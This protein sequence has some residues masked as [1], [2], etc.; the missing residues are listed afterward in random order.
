[1]STEVVIHTLPLLCS[2]FAR[3]S[4]QTIRTGRNASPLPVPFDISIIFSRFCSY[5]VAS[6]D[7]IIVY[8]LYMFSFLYDSFMIHFL[9]SGDSFIFRNDSNY[10]NDSS[11]LKM[12]PIF[13]DSSDVSNLP[14]LIF[15]PDSFLFL[16][17]LLVLSFAFYWFF[18]LDSFSMINF[19]FTRNFFLCFYF[20]KYVFK[21]LTS[22]LLFLFYLIIFTRNY[23]SHNSSDYCFI[24]LSS[25]QF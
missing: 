25:H 16:C 12:I 2:H 18:T 14:N 7:N 13:C 8:T 10:L 9:I 22:S 5:H 21:Q 19:I 1:M 24:N 17:W 11:F 3:V 23:C 6:W 4:T 15:V 20:Y